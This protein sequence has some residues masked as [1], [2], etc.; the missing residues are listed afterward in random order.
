M[1]LDPNRLVPITRAAFARALPQGA[2]LDTDRGPLE[3]T[4]YAPGVFRIRLGL[5]RFDYGFLAEE[6][7]AP[8]CQVERSGP[9]G[10][11]ISTHGA[12]LAIEG[13]PLRI[14]VERVNGT[15]L[16][17]G[18]TIV[19]DITGHG[20]AA[21]FDQPPGEPVYGPGLDGAGPG[22][23]GPPFAWSPRGWGVLAHTA[24][25]VT[26]QAGG[27]AF[28]LHVQDATL[29]LFLF[30]ADDGPGLLDRYTWLTGRPPQVPDWSLGVW[31]ACGD[32]G[33]A[34]EVVRTAAEM[35]KRRIPFDTLVL[36]GEGWIRADGPEGFRWDA[37][38]IPDPTAFH[39]FIKALGIKVVAAHTPC[40]PVDSP[41]FAGHAGNGW[42]LRD[43]Q[44]GEPAVTGAGA[45]ACGIVDFT[46]ADA[47]ADWRD[48]YRPLFA[49]GVDAI[50]AEPPAIPADAVSASGATGPHLASVYPL[51]HS[52]GVFEAA[53]RYGHGLP[54]IAGHAG[55][56]AGQRFPT[57]TGLPAE[58][59]WNGFAASIREALDRG[60]RGTPWW[61]AQI[62]GTGIPRPDTELYI[63]WAQQG[64]FASHTRIGGA[65]GLEPWSFGTEA[66]NIVR[67]WLEFRYRLIPYIQGVLEQAQQTG[68]PVMRAMALAFPDQPAAWAFDT[69]YMFG[70]ALLVAPVVQPG[71]RVQVHLPEGGWYDIWSGERLDGGRTITVDATG[72]QIPLYGRE[73]ES[74]ALG[75]MIQHTGEIDPSGRLDSLWVFGKPRHPP[76]V[77]RMRPTLVRQ[78][79]GPT[80]LVGMPTTMTVREFGE[81]KPEILEDAILFHP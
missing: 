62:G 61:P 35:R 50:Q 38:R 77:G 41:M 21:V 10:V 17:G 55:W 51:L 67:V 26:T 8:D 11:R 58:G 80:L 28:T 27:R 22:N 6:P 70:P 45:R 72:A 4:A 9:A 65:A 24:G 75:P 13:A 29:D 78:P 43:T 71:G 14:S 81:L 25:A 12:A 19:A 30:V 18:L 68:L 47:Y 32:S 31:L 7:A 37:D 20:W 59:T 33:S 46:N 40:L 66:E 60:R 64:I 57:P 42:L 3:A 48:R 36:K 15:P 76:L 63:R 23:G 73:G 16:P 5:E 34:E 56:T 49:Q 44:S 1:T 69:Q 39:G 52:A 74:L 79:N 53:T 54:I 2:I